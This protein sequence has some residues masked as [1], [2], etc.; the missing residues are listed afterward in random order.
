MNAPMHPPFTPADVEALTRSLADGPQKMWIGGRAV[1][2]ASGQTF[3]SFNPSTGELLAKIASGGDEDVDRAVKAARRALEGPWSKLPGG[4]RTKLLWKLAD[5]IEA[6]AVNLALLESMD[7]GK[8]FGMALFV[9]MPMA[10]QALRYFAGWAD[11]LRGDSPQPSV[12]GEWHCYTIRQPVG[13]VGQIVA[14][15]FPLAMA[16]GKIAPALA[17]GCTVVLKP[18]EQTTLS[19]LRLG[20]LIAHAGFPE[21]VVNIVSGLGKQAGQALVEHP[22]VD[23]ISFTGST[24]TGKHILATAANTLKSVTLELGGKSPNII[25]ADADLDKAIEAASMGV[26]FNTGQVCVARSRMFVHKK[27]YDQVIAG[28]AAHV[29]HL[30]VG[31]NLAPDSVLGP[32][33]SK[34]QMDKIGSYVRSGR[35]QGAEVVFGGGNAGGPGY[36]VEPTLLAGVR[37]DMTVM[38]EEIFGP[39]LCALP[40]GDEDLEQVAAMANDSIYGLAASVWT[41]DLSTAHK[42]ARRIQSGLVEIN[43]APPMMFDLPFGGFKQS[44]L[45]RENG[46]EGVESYTET[47]TVTIGL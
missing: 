14:W 1:A 35:E 42:L 4:E 32:V 25:F 41:R 6:N 5:L 46:R 21:G 39:V 8:P 40:F 37:P 10:V 15:N 22:G 34:E 29:K 7:N 3:D 18:A 27:V 38:Q 26:F 44:G 45:G 13:V 11:K 28:V 24:A 2:S 12:P 30:K 16:V 47:K 20:E 17:A 31:P 36:F 43:C 19:A 9:D 33:V 23:K